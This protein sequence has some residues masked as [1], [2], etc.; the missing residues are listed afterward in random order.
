M[1]FLCLVCAFQFMCSTFSIRFLC[2]HRMDSITLCSVFGLCYCI[3]HSNHSQ[4]GTE[5]HFSLKFFLNLYVAS[6]FKLKLCRHCILY[7][8][9]WFER[10][11]CSFCSVCY[12]C[13]GLDREWDMLQCIIGFRSIRALNPIHNLNHVRFEIQLYCLFAY[14]GTQRHV[15]HW[16]L[17]FFLVSPVTRLPSLSVCSSL[18]LH[19]AR[20][21]LH[22][23]TSNQEVNNSEA[24]N[25]VAVL[26]RLFSSLS[27]YPCT[28]VIRPN[29]MSIENR[30]H[31][32][33]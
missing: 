4:K 17:C 1:L 28:H 21:I 32:S 13:C 24:S 20:E 22:N 15:N 2:I 10:S 16:W 33:N 12:L 26:C 11:F 19:R 25:I 27:S 8:T 7:C 5:R 3:S 6:P 31:H 23:Q 18:L 9:W 30:L 14:K 29:R